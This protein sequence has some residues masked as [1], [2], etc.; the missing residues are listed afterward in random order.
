M[1]E[2]R[3][4]FSTRR[5]LSGGIGTLTTGALS[6]SEKTNFANAGDP[7]FTTPPGCL[8]LHQASFI[9]GL[10]AF[11][12]KTRLTDYNF[13]PFPAINPTYGTDYMD[14]PTDGF[15]LPKKGKTL[16]RVLYDTSLTAGAL[17][18]SLTVPRADLIF[19]IS[20]PICWNLANTGDSIIAAICLSSSFALLWS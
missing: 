15:I 9:T 7:L 3:G 14:A 6:P 20:P 4:V 11:A 8:F 16:Q 1:G 19:C 2:G 12:T 5:A 10:G 17:L 18:N 13:F